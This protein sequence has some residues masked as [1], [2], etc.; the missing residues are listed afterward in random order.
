MINDI[1]ELQLS[2]IK[3][4]YNYIDYEEGL[5][6]NYRG[7]ENLTNLDRKVLKPML[8]D[9][10]NKGYV[11]FEK[12]LVND[13]GEFAG[14][15]YGLTKKGEATAHPCDICGKYAVYGYK[16]KKECEIHYGKSPIN[17]VDD[18]TLII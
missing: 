18:V 12:G 7:L 13:E 15:G 4:I 8:L 14:S 1:T 6:F 11:V 10:R 3:S 5:C 17:I 2:I 16:G 9:L